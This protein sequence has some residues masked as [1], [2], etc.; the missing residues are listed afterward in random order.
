MKCGLWSK[1]STHYERIIVTSPTLNVWYTFTCTYSMSSRTLSAYKDGSLVGTYVVPS[2]GLTVYSS[3][4]GY[5]GVF[6]LAN[7]NVDI[8]SAYSFLTEKN[9]TEVSAL[10]NLMIL[11]GTPRALW[12]AW[13]DDVDQWT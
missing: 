10:H 7:A 1:S 2:G 9:A 12:L 5:T 8:K 13:F 11:D 3:G 6:P 4:T